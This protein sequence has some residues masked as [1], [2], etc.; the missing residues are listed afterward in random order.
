[1]ISIPAGYVLG[2]FTTTD[3]LV[4]CC[5]SRQKVDRPCIALPKA[6]AVITTA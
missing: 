3:T 1:M 4:L 6:E 2:Y 5:F